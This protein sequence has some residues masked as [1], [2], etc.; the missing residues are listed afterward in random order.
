MSGK[1]KDM[2]GLLSP[3]GTAKV[4][5]GV[6]QRTLKAVTTTQ[7]KEFQAITFRFPA[8]M[9]QELRQARINHGNKPMVQIL[10]EAFE[11]WKAKHEI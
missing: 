4:S 11:L 5:E 9:A 6:P 3:K 1:A 10:E 7:P 8:Q 2:S